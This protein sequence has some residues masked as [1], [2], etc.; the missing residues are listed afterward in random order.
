[1]KLKTHYI[2]SSIAAGSVPEISKMQKLAFCIGSMIPDISYTQF[3]RPHFMK[4]SGEYVFRKLE[5]LAVTDSFFKAYEYGKMAHYLSDFCCSVHNTRSVK[6][7]KFHF[8]YERLLEKYIVINK[9]SI[10]KKVTEF[11]SELVDLK[12]LLKKYKDG[13]KANFE[14]DIF[15]AIRACMILAKRVTKTKKE[16]VR[17]VRFS[18]IKELLPHEENLFGLMWE[19]KLNAYR[20]NTVKWT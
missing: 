18:E 3:Y 5:K 1:M 14:F 10:E 17:K 4:N 6:T 13:E 20:N 19:K 7:A 9:Q 16:R 8:A 12:E 11:E 2:M 15:M